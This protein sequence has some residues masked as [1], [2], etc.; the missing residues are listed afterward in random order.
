MSFLDLERETCEALLPGLLKRLGEVPLMELERSGG[1]GIGLFRGAGGAGLLVPKSH[2]GLGATAV[3]AVRITRALAACSPSVAV[4]TTMHQF[5]VAS[6][7][8]LARSSTG[9]EWMLLEAAAVDGRLVASGFAEGSPGR[10]ILT[11]TMTARRDG[12]SWRVSGAKRPCSLSRSMDLLTASVAVPTDDG[13]TRLG[14]ALIPAESPGI[15][16]E[17]FWSSW[18]LAGAESDAV[19]LD[20]V[21]VHPDLLV[22]PEIGLDGQL[23]DLQTIGFIW[24]ELLVT[25]CYLG[26]AAALVERVL[27]SGR[28]PA[29]ERAALATAIEGA[30][31]MLDGTARNL[32]DGDGGNDALGRALVVRF[33]AADAIAGAVR[34]AVELLGGMAFVTSPE[35]AYLAAASHAIAFH[36]PSR[37]S[38]A[39]EMA[40]WFGGRPLVLS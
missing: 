1:P 18:V 30:A 32:D 38:V 14:V 20:D 13:S 23:D 4:G 36:P 17:P 22:Y 39:A 5:S 6:L 12:E 37:A 24:F 2:Q 21:E 11:P 3:Q 29:T 19:I 31:L 7:V 26:V 16:V 27:K 34:G 15:R 33:A 10:G 28:G 25:A 9:F 35:V 40:D 8:A